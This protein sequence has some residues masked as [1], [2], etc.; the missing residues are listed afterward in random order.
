[1]DAAAQQ[2]SAAGPSG[3][4]SIDTFIE[5]SIT[6]LRFQGT[7]DESFD[8]KRLASGIKATTLILDMGAVRK[9]SSFGIRE[10]TDFIKGVERSVDTLIAIE[11]TPK[12][13]DQLNMVSQFL[14]AKGLVF[15]FYAPYRCDYCDVDR[16]IL[17]QVDRDAA[18]IR[19]L[20]PSEQLCETC[21]RPSYFDEEPASFFAYLAQQRP[22]ELAPAIAEFLSSKLRYSVTGGDRRLHIDK[23]IEGR[24]TYLKFVGNLDGSFPSG[25]IAEGLEGTIVVDV[26]GIGTIDLAGAA[27]WRNF[28][29]QTKSAAER[30]FLVGCPPVLLERLTRQG[31]L[32]DQVISFTMPYS[33][34]KC[35]TTAS[36]VIDVEQHY[37]ILKFATPPEMKC[38]HCKSATVC[39]APE[40]LLSRLRT[41]PRVEID[42]GL[43]KFIKEMRDRKPVQPKEP[44]QPGVATGAR[45]G[46]FTGLIVLALV[47]AAVLI[48]VNWYQTREARETQKKIEGVIASVEGNQGVV[49]RNFSRPVWITSDTPGSAFCTDN[50]N[51]LSCV[52]VSAYTDSREDGRVE[53]SNA[54]LEEMANSIGL[55][56]D[57]ALFQERVRPIY[58]DGRAKALN[59]LE[60]VRGTP[61]V[62]EY[63]KARE[64]VGKARKAVAEALAATGG[65]AAPA[66][67]AAWYW[68]EYEKISGTGNE[69]LVF[70]RY[71]I[72]LSSMKSLMISYSDVIDAGGGAKVVTMFPSIAW[73]MPETSG[74]ALVV[75]S[76]GDLAK[77]GVPENALVTSV[78]GTAVKTAPDM[79]A[80]LKKAGRSAKLTVVMPDGTVKQI[81][82]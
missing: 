42:S 32:G 29:T 76:G 4:L 64:K 19:S 77:L 7:I 24:N 17:F 68:E 43:R 16:R 59:E 63:R 81:G 51:R 5:G 15:S 39:V 82:G 75:K 47:A 55:K 78:D 49:Q 36:Q 44:K 18:S 6:C 3:N 69:F 62:I 74:G 31:D 20:R 67:Q 9:I 14:G 60:S 72:S 38:A 48:G 73:E 37:D 13:V 57:S 56:I 45:L 8:G 61:G 10:W 2:Q 80:R 79:V 28:I 33:C 27:E 53:A 71:D 22:F 23:H 70:V 30:V 41:L 52:G 34:S 35:A 12:V 66:Q 50:V 11:C 65:A 40:I 58:E 54:A 21:S 25:K 26:S 1:M 46:M